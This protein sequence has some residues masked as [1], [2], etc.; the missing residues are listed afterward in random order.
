MPIQLTTPFATGALDPGGPYQKAKIA[1]FSV[2]VEARLIEIVVHYGNVVD[3]AWIPGML[4]PG[5]TVKTFRIEGSAYDALVAQ[6]S[7]GAGELYYDKVAGALY[8]WLLD[9]GHYAGTVQ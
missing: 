6:T 7:A 3:G 2:H 5:V 9:N 8:Q 4:V 1:V